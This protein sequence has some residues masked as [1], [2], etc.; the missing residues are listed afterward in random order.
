ML[1]WC[2]RVEAVWAYGLWIQKEFAHAP[3]G[4]DCSL[5]ARP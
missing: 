3:Y 5:S 2:P 4:W 1:S